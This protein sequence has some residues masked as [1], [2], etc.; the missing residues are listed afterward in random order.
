[1]YVYFN[2]QCLIKQIVTRKAKNIQIPHTSPAAID[3]QQKA[4]IQIA[5]L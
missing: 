1:M 4:K 5:T 2:R 3:A